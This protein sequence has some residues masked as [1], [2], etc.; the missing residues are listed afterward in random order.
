MTTIRRNEVTTLEFTAKGEYANPFREVEFRTDITDASGQTMQIP[1]FWDGQQSWKFRFASAQEG[2][3]T[4]VTHCNHAGDTGL[5]QQRGTIQVRGQNAQ[6]QLT[7]DGPV[8]IDKDKRHFAHASGRPFSWLGDTWWM[9]L[10]R[11]LPLSGFQDLIADRVRK[12]FSVVQIIAGLY[13]DM[14]WHDPRGEGD[15]GFPWDKEF[16]TINPAYFQQ[17][18]LRISLLVDAGLLPCI[19]G[20]WGYFMDF[21]GAETLKLH[22][23]NLIAR[24]AAMPVVWCIAG[25]GL[26]PFYLHGHQIEDMNQWEKER[27]AAWSE[28]AR[29]IQAQDGFRRPITIH[30]TRFGRQQVDD[31]TTL[32]FEMLQTGHAG[33]PSLTSTIDMLEESLDA[34]PVMPVII[35]EVNY[36]GILESSG[37]EIQRFLYWSSMLSGSAGFTY[38]ANGLWQVNG[39]EIPYGPSPHGMAWGGPS[40]REASRLAGSQQI[41]LAKQLLDTLPWWTI[42]PSPESVSHRASPE[43]RIGPYAA[44]LEGDIR[45]VFIPAPSIFLIR[46]GGL[47]LQN[48]DPGTQ[49]H[50]FWFNPKTGERTELGAITPEPNGRYFLPTPQFIQDWVFVASP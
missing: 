4:Y 38:G 45:V 17:M 16:L 8:I 40:W 15:A 22:W 14:D 46:R 20:F 26:M 2:E 7:V 43:D 9:G 12:G 33:F 39:E 1:G 29:W 25:E 3:Y 36:E 37:P 44:I 41:G 31:A 21:A 32:D 47:T 19:V 48:L 30:P 24:Y 11:R 35:S 42:R 6:S 34:T 18:D 23:R 28:M 27:S 50:T 49:Y 13:P 5:H 10:T